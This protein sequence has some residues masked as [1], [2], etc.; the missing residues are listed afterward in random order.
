MWLMLQQPKPDNYVIAT[1]ETHTV[2]EFVEEAFSILDLDWKKYVEIDPRYMRPT[3]VDVLQ[4]D[5]SKAKTILNWQ[6]RTKFATL[7]RFMI[8]EDMKLAEAEKKLSLG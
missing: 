4:G 3:E 8:M 6:P 7:V 2:R 5:A 1:G